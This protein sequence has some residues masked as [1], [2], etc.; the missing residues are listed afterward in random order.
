L[1]FLPII[2][3]IKFILKIV[4]IS[5]SHG[6]HRQMDLPAGDMLIHA[7]DVSG[8][9]MESQI[10]DFLDWF[11]IQPHRNKIMIAGNHDFYFDEASETAIKDLIPCNIIY[12]NDSGVTIDGINIWGSPVSTWFYN[13]AFNRHKGS[14]IQKHWELIPHTTDI[15]ITHGP[16]EGI[17][18]RTHNGVH[19]GCDNLLKR[20]QEIKPKIHAFGHIH[21]G[22]GSEEQ[23]GVNFINAA[24]L[25]ASYQLIN[26]PIVV[27]W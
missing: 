19:V 10:V 6:Y 17:R 14:D 21:E 11:T 23:Y 18:D 27:N 22:Y 8:R 13:W 4:I 20:V 7:G 24:V 26:P 2:N 5:D 9:G 3:A 25:S 12:L 1:L 15:L 16:A